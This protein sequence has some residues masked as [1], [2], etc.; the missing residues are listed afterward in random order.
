MQHMA[1]FGISITG[2][3]MVFR[4]ATL[5]FSNPGS[6][7]GTPDSKFV[8]WLGRGPF[9]AKHGTRNNMNVW[10][11]WP[12]V[13]FYGDLCEG[14]GLYGTQEAFGQAHFPP[15]LA[16][17][18]FCKVFPISRKKPWPPWAP[19]IPLGPGAL[20][21]QGAQWAIWAQGA[22]WA[23]GPFWL[24]GPTGFQG[25]NR[26]LWAFWK[27]GTCGSMDGLTKA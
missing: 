25:P 22:L 24:K 19:W 16:G 2:F 26:A 10:K 21:A 27:R 23:L 15:N 4:Y 6:I 18:A 9:S 13:K 14:I 12:H 7:C 5:I 17:K 8:P 11:K 20:W 1:P 3:C